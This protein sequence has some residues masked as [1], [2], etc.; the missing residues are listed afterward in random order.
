MSAE[1]IQKVDDLTKMVTTLASTVKTLS[2]AKP[3]ESP[4][5]AKM[6]AKIGD[7]EKFADGAKAAVENAERTTIIT[8][9]QLEGRVAFD[10]NGVAY[11]TDALQKMDLPLLKFASR[12][13]QL[14]PLVAKATYTGTG[15]PPDE[16]TFTDASGKDLSADEIIEKS[17]GSKYGD[18]NKMISSANKN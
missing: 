4:E 16:R 17:W 9:M 13:S 11:K 18:I 1:L 3:V 15:T 6:V 5:L 12:N 8:K 7:L 2:E 14:L 10:E